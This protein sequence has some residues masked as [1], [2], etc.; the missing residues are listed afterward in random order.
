MQVYDNDLLPQEEEPEESDEDGKVDM[1]GL[2]AG[3]PIPA[4]S[5]ASTSPAA[6]VAATGASISSS[7]SGAAGASSAS[8]PAPPPLEEVVPP[9][10][11]QTWSQIRL[12]ALEAT[13]RDLRLMAEK[14]GRDAREGHARGEEYEALDMRNY[15]GPLSMYARLM[16]TVFSNQAANMTS[17]RTFSEFRLLRDRLQRER[18]EELTE[19]PNSWASLATVPPRKRPRGE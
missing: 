10:T 4:S 19:V 5:S 3:N 6:A 18:Q 2:P 7:S 11:S 14:H 8:V 1:T 17:V 16:R 13:A 15:L 12:M 9:L